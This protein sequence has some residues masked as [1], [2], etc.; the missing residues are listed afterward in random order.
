MRSS[1]TVEKCAAQRPVIASIRNIGMVSDATVGVAVHVVGVERFPNS[2]YWSV[3][4]SNRALC[5]CPEPLLP[6]VWKAARASSMS[7]MARPPFPPAARPPR[8]GTSFGK[9]MRSG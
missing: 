9:V 2:S 4:S 1:C 8:I 6:W 5:L 7:D 3:T